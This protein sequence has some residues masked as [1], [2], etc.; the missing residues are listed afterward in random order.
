LR[1]ERFDVVFVDAKMP[2]PDGMELARKIRA[3]GPNKRSTIVMITGE[4]GHDFMRQIFDAGVNFVGFKPVDRRAL[5]RLLRITQGSVERE[6]RRYTRINA[7]CRVGMELAG[8]SSD[9]TTIDISLT[10]MHVKMGRCFPVNSIVQTTLELAPDTQKLCFQSRIVRH[11]DD[12]YMGIEYEELTQAESRRLEVFLLPRIL[13]IE[14][15]K[16]SRP[17]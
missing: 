11:I 16:P 15:S 4:Q 14:S 9:G 8:Q 13:K 3:F 5:M 2:A 1:H 17:R 6:R 7:L 12:D 10:G